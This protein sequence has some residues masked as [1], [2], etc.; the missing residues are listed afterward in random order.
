MPDALTV[1]T[2]PSADDRPA[3]RAAER[4]GERPGERIVLPGQTP[5]GQPILAVLVKRSYTIV[6]NQRCRRAP[7]DRKL[8]AADTHFGDPM[9]STVR[10]ETD[11]VPFK[12]ATDVVFEAIAYAP[13]GRPTEELL[14]SVGIGDTVVRSVHVIGDRRAHYHDGGP[15]TFSDPMPFTTMP[16][17]YERAFGGVDVRSDPKLACAYGRNPLGRGFAIR[18]APEVVDDLELPNLE[19]P[20]DRL[21]PDRLCCGHFV[22]MD[23]LPEPASFGWTMKLWRPRMLLAG[24]MPADAALA[25]ELRQAARQA[26]PAQ[27]RAMYDQA[28]LPPMNF[29]FFNGASDGLV[30]PYMRGDERVRTKHLTPDGR[31]DFMLPGE[32]PCVGLD[33]GFG[34]ATP[35]L[36]LHT[37]MIRLEERE[38]DLVWRGAV[39][40]P[41][42]NW[43]PEMRRL[44][45]SIS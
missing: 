21:T 36:V 28:E 1:G 43:L 4:P 27:Q 26:V 35:E 15:P 37:V 41:G 13:G 20:A 38:L 9:N 8:C 33:I 22:H 31:F 44:D 40:Y 2:K 23:Q 11:F 25:R 6:P 30:L 34:A 5:D 12:L 3:E 19:L 32:R 42:L 14:A 10:H 18:N 39:P 45:L 17:R 7:K 24:V 16:I 29:R